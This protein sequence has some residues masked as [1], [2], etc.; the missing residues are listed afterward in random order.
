MLS[1]INPPPPQQ[2]PQQALTLAAAQ[3]A[4]Q[5]LQMQQMVASAPAAAAGGALVGAP[6]GMYPAYAFPLGFPQPGAAFNGALTAAHVF[7]QQQLPLQVPLPLMLP[8]GMA[9]ALN[10]QQQELAEL[11][12]AVA[13]SVALAGPTAIRGARAAVYVAAWRHGSS[14][15]PQTRRPCSCAHLLQSGSH[16]SLAPRCVVFKYRRKGCVATPG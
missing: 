13:A 9:F 1:I 4:A 14:L 10:Q 12:R 8:Q 6:P 3:Q 15:G 7:Q 11:S 16:A 2:Q 5:Q